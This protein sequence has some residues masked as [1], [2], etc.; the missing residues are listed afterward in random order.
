MPRFAVK[1][2]RLREAQGLSQLKLAKRAKV[3]QVYIS[4]LE[5]GIKIN[6]G[7]ETVRKLAR[8]LGV[9]VVELME[10]THDAEKERRAMKPY[11][12]HVYPE[13]QRWH[14]VILL[15]PTVGAGTS[16]V[17]FESRAENRRGYA[18]R[19]EARHAALLQKATLPAR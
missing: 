11:D 16:S 7:I 18:T 17:I 12:V 3:G 4:E 10:G 13:D 8:A 2:K 5:A 15:I 6:P 9:K 14:F 19:E 1:L